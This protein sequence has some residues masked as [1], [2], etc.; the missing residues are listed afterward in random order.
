[1]NKKGF[2]LVEALVVIAIVALLV[3]ILVP[4][5][6]TLINKNNEKSCN[7][8]INNIKSSAKV[9]V[10]TNKYDLEFGCSAPDNTKRITLQTLIDTGDLTTDDNGKIIN[11]VK[12]EEIP[13]TTEVEVTYNCKTKDFTYSV[14][15]IVCT[16]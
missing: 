4:N 8:L 13:L 16:K 5:V 10:T 14:I 1:M 15:G 11:P 9:Y 2:T 7:S 12:D 6:F 3:L